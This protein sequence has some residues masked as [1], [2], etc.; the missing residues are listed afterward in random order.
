MGYKL[1]ERVLKITCEYG[2]EP[3]KKNFEKTHI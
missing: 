1:V 3:K 2:V